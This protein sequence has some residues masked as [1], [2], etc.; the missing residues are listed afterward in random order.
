VSDWTDAWQEV[1]DSVGRDFSDGV[2][3]YGAAPVEAESIRRYLEPL[4]LDC[5]LH[6]DAGVARAHGY[7][8]IVAPYTAG[9]CWAIPAMWRPGDGP[10]FTDEARDAQPT[11]TPINNTNFPLGPPTS[12]FFA[13]DLE[14]EF[15][16]PV[17]VGER[18]G[19]RGHRLLACTPKQTAVGR[20]AF[21]VWESELIVGQGEVVARMR[22][23]VY[24]YQPHDTADAGA[25]S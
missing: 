8:G 21:M 3:R 7:S 20:G 25:G 13:T 5:A 15:E 9:P 19:R 4:E 1:V 23:G 12:G 24:A 10:L 14:F 11:R 6:Y 22:A 18:V 2:V 17:V 16:R